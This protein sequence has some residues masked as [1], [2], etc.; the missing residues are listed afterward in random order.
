MGFAI[1]YDT[2]VHH[3][4]SIKYLMFF[5]IVVNIAIQAFLIVMIFSKSMGSKLMNFVYKMLVKFHYKKAEAFKV[6]A[7]KQLEEYH[8]CAEHIKKNKV[9]FVKVILTTVVQLSLYH[10]IPYFVYRSLGLSEANIMK[11]VL[12]ESVLYI[13]VAS[14]PLPGSMGASEGSF[15]VMFKVFFPEVLLGSAMIISRA[16]SFYLFVVISLVLIVAFMLYDDYKRKRLA[17]N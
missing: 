11:F 1:N 8:E 16:I 13:S 17:K 7:D 6:Q 4:G 15:V 5:G 2:L 9:L 14:L 10:G 3:I 12:M